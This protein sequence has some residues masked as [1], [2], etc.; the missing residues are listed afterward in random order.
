MIPYVIFIFIFPPPRYASACPVTVDIILAT[1]SRNEN[2]NIVLS[3]CC[4]QNLIP[5]R[6]HGNMKTVDVYSK[7]VVSESVVF[8]LD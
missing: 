7:T 6:Q 4:I 2:N 3:G 8:K 5:D 1:M